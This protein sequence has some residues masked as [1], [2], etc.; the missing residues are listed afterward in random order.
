MQE[1]LS[2]TLFRTRE[3]LILVIATV[4]YLAIGV[5]AKLSPSVASFFGFVGLLAIYMPIILVLIFVR[6]GGYK[7]DFLS[8]WF[9]TAVMLVVAIIPFIVVAKSTFFR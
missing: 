1:H 7:R 8:D 6:I 4:I 5:S 3:G 9:N 2:R